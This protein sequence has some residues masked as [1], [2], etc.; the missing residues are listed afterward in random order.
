MLALNSIRDAFSNRVQH[1]NN[2]EFKVSFS[3]GVASINNH[4]ELE[5]LL[6]AA[7]RALYQAKEEGRNTIEIA[8]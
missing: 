3:A 4:Q 1:I 5:A 2:F 8:K 6:A 7:D